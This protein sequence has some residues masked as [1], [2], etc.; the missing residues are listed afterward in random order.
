MMRQS[1]GGKPTSIAFRA[2]ASFC[3]SAAVQLLAT[4]VFG[5]GFV[6]PMFV[7]L[8]IL[9]VVLFA[10][11]IPYTLLSLAFSALVTCLLVLASNLESAPLEP[12][13]VVDN[14]VH[15]ALHA[16]RMDELVGSPR[17]PADQDASLSVIQQP[18]NS[19]SSAE[20]HMAGAAPPAASNFDDS[21]LLALMKRLEDAMEPY[22]F[23]YRQRLGLNS[24]TGVA[25]T[26]ELGY[27]E[28]QKDTFL[29]GCPDGGCKVFATLKQ[30]QE[31]CSKIIVTCGGVTQTGKEH[32]EVRAG[33]GTPGK[34]KNSEKSWIR[35]RCPSEPK[36]ATAESLWNVFA[37]TVDDALK[38][39][40]LRLMDKPPAPRQ[41]DSIFLSISSYRDDN[42]PPTVRKAFER[43]DD[44]SRV[45]VGVVQV[46][47][48]QS[49]GCKWARG[50]GK[51]R[52]IFDRPGADEDCLSAYCA[53]T[54]GKPHCEGGRVR[55]L[56]LS[57]AVA[58]GP[59]FTRYLNSQL[60]QGE[61]Y[62]MQIDSHINFRSGWDT[63]IVNQMKRTPSFPN[64]VISNYPPVGTPKNN[65]PWPKATAKDGEKPPVALCTSTFEDVNGRKTMRMQHT[66]RKFRPSANGRDPLEPRQSGFIAAG[67]FIAHAS[68]LQK[69][70]FDPFMPYLFMGEEII[71]SLRF[72][73]A[74]FDIYGPV[75][76]I[77]SHD[78][79]R[80]D[81]PKFWETVNMVFGDGSVHNAITALVIQRVQHLVGFPE[82]ATTSQ[83]TPVSPNLLIRQDE[84][85]EG[86]VRSVLDYINM[87][88]LD[89]THK[90]QQVPPW[91]VTGMRPPA[92]HS[93]T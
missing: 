87:M 26:C 58:M 7:P 33:A 41:D 50:W 91:C 53:S 8:I 21:H 66:F 44:P 23:A 9:L 74:G 61:T 20:E 51:T 49:S 76:D 69:I 18:V 62:Y 28:E 55:I 67:F 77:V 63:E 73:T 60:W 57:E 38:D 11:A 89:L 34:S 22:Q 56:R 17:Q 6:H 46:N 54:D 64:S 25:T 27:E 31:A 43:A 65:A 1:K 48:E 47:C 13:R 45:Y 81:A 39:P 14:E 85:G 93:G 35:K 40:S 5:E 24:S 83:L 37:T 29:W 80:H 10:V 30:A 36:H 59:F 32:F 68:F 42:C 78:Y 4:Y 79:G 3:A 15:Q 52:E 19:G 12:A 75:V 71:L 82:A 84:F 88:G 16:R 2:I 86:G 92:Q 90:R 72:W 70:P